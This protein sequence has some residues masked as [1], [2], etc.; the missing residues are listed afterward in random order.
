MATIDI[1]FA[2]VSGIEGHIQHQTDNPVLAWI[3]MCKLLE[4]NGAVAKST[5]P[6]ANANGNHAAQPA[7]PPTW[8]QPQTMPAA[9]PST[10]VP[11]S[12][13]TEPACPDHGQSRASRVPGVDLY[14][15]A[16]DDTGSYCPWVHPP[17]APKVRRA[18]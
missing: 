8:P 17:R 15:P 5:R 4:S 1:F 11:V 10:T 7:R 9:V 14:C 16:Q 13:E 2:T 6:S 3:E 18:K 12:G